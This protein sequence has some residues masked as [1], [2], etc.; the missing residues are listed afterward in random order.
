MLKRMFI[1][2][3]FF[4]IYISERKKRNFIR[5]RY[6]VSKHVEEINDFVNRDLLHSRNGTMK[7]LMK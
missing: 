5:E 4:S 6:T 3:I 2:S 7:N 1:A